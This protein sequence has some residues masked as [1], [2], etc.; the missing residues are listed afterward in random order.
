MGREATGLLLRHLPSS[1]LSPSLE[2][3]TGTIGLM[4]RTQQSEVLSSRPNSGLS[5]QWPPKPLP[6][7]I[8]TPGSPSTLHPGYSVR[9][10]ERDGK[11][12]GS[13]LRLHYERH[14]SFCLGLPPLRPC[15]GE[16]S[17]L[18]VGSAVEKPWQ[19][20]GRG[21]VPNSTWVSVGADAPATV[22]P[23]EACELMRLNV[24][25]PLKFTH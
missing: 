22:N 20:G 13:P 15:F 24:C 19:G 4:Q 7:G 10:V 23:S 25:S 11:D 5:R 1:S 3:Q 21:P 17:G 18:V 14:S 2:E 8:H 9:P 6:P 16:A 12:G